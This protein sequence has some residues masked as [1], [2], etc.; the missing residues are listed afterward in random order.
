M[1]A[2]SHAHPELDALLGDAARRLPIDLAR[3]LETALRARCTTPPPQ[4]AFFAAL[5]IIRHGDCADGRAWT[6]TRQ[7]FISAC[8]LASVS[9][10]LHGLNVILDL[11]HAADRSREAAEEEEQ[12]GAFVID[13]LL[14]A[15]RQ[16]SSY[17]QASLGPPV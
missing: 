6:T 17:A 16:L 13:G 10:S 7:S 2:T 15:A 11:L 12:V 14:V 8:D 4:P 3:T 1:S 5:D 9:R